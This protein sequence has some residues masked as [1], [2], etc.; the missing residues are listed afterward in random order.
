MGHLVMGSRLYR[1][2]A[3][4]TEQKIAIY[5]NSI[6][7]NILFYLISIASYSLSAFILFRLGSS[8]VVLSGSVLALFIVLII[9]IFSL[10]LSIPQNFS[11]LQLCNYAIMACLS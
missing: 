10:F 1:K 3:S 2:P 8:Y 6:G 4:V 5:K 9:W 7:S 11:C